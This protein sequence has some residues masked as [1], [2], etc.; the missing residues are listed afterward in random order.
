MTDSFTATGNKEA[1]AVFC[2]KNYV[3]LYSKPW[4]MDAV[5]GPENWDVWLYEKGGTVQAAM[6]YYMERRGDYRYITKA[7]LSQTHGI[8][9]SENDKRK[10][11]KQAEFEEKII[12]EACAYIAGMNLDVY[13]QQYS[14][15]FTNWSPFYWNKY[16]CILRYSYILEDTSD[17]DAI[18]NN[19]SA[20]YRNEIRKGQKLVTV[21]DEISE[22]EFYDEHEKVFLKQGKQCP[23]DRAFW[24]RLLNA[25]TARNAGKMLCARDADGNVNAL[26]FI[27]WDERYIYHLLGGYMPEYA[28]NQAY[29][30]LTHHAISI[31]HGMKLGYDF[32][33]SML[34]QVARSFRQ[35]GAVP[36]PYYRIRKV[37]NADIVRKEAEDSILHNK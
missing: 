3:P 1:Y 25:C 18:W 28:S 20:E 29:P 26:L 30:V 36:M 10:L 17:L 4:W 33:G 13:E 12:N 31:A 14:H 6:P 21:T 22:D 8:T 15:T 2:E 16:S 24:S 5:C 37:F 34:K 9:F 32:E 19:Y 11:A 7:P 35:F 23:F 27:V